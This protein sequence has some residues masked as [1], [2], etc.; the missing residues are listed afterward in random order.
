MTLGAAALTPNMDRTPWGKRQLMRLLSAAIWVSLLIVFLTRFSFSPTPP[1]VRSVFTLP[2]R[3]TVDFVGIE[4]ATN[5]LTP[6]LKVYA[7]EIDDEHA[8]WRYGLNP[9]EPNANIVIMWFPSYSAAA[10]Q[11]NAWVAEFDEWVSQSG[12]DIVVREN[13]GY[14]PWGGHFKGDSVFL[15]PDFAVVRSVYIIQKCQFVLIYRIF[16]SAPNF[17]KSLAEAE[18]A[19]NKFACLPY[20]DRGPIR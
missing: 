3:W 8:S 5:S 9:Y 7:S 13:S 10:A 15:G 16:G 4:F 20:S 6:G 1:Y 12:A 2:Y 18:I 17:E 19:L 14:W 11:Y